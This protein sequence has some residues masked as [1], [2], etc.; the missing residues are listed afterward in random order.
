MG[1]QVLGADVAA[2]VDVQVA[3]RDGRP[4]VFE[5]GHVADE[6]TRDRQGTPAIPGRVVAARVVP[7]EARGPKVPCVDAHRP[8]RP[9][10]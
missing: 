5:P 9:S 6:P 1:L 3:G 10:P 7:A 2:P 4:L 8:H